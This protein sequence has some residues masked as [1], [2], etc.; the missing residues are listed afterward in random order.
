MFSFLKK[1]HIKWYSHCVDHFVDHNKFSKQNKNHNLQFYNIKYIHIRQN[2]FLFS[3]MT[4]IEA[5]RLRALLSNK[6][7]TILNFIQE[8]K[9]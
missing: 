4:S 9:K 1:L 5:S 6:I 7:Q 8:I 3:A 2:W